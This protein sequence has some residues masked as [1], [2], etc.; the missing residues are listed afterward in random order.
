[1]GNCRRCRRDRTC[2]ATGTA[3]P[4]GRRHSLDGRAGRRRRR[5]GRRLVTVGH[6]ER[7]GIRQR[8]PDSSAA[9]PALRHASA[10]AL[11]ANVTWRSSSTLAP[12]TGP[13]ASRAAS[14]GSSGSGADRRRNGGLRLGVGVRGAGVRR[15][16]SGCV[17]DGDLI[18][19][20]GCHQVGLFC[21][22]LR[23]GV[24]EVRSR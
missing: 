1:M 3:R 24:P 13:P 11:V 22:L 4:R 6:L 15:G 20:V 18:G 17:G 23:R 12:P 21:G 14:A 8:L 5:L 10:C 16:G 7:R 19:G 2:F 9:M